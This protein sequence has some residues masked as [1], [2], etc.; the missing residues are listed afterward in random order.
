MEIKQTFVHDWPTPPEWQEELETVAPKRGDLSYLKLEWEPGEEWDPVQRW[1]IYQMIPVGGNAGDD[2]FKP[3][4]EGPN[5]RLFGYYDQVRKKWVRRKGAP[6]ISLHQWKLYKETGRLGQP[7][8]VIQG[9]RGGHRYD[10]TKTEK[11]IIS[12]KTGQREVDAP[13][14]GSLPY[15]PF[16]NRVLNKISNLDRLRRDEFAVAFAYKHPEQF[17]AAEERALQVAENDVWQ[18]LESQIDDRLRDLP[19]GYVSQMA[20][21]SAAPRIFNPG[22]RG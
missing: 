1:V 14:M 19:Y 2:L 21:L 3:M 12:R 16:D 9:D 17:E 6:M 5:P 4:L 7:Y 22:I 15:A 8:W 18:W 10:F 20:G 11:M 13:L